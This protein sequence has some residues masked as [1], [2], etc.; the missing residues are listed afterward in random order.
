MVDAVYRAPGG[1]ELT[2]QVTFQEDAQVP[3]DW[4][5][6]IP[7]GE[8]GQLLYR[9]S[10][11][12]SSGA[13]IES[14][15]TPVDERTIYVN[16]LFEASLDLTFFV[17]VDLEQF[18]AVFID[19]SY[20]DRSNNYERQERAELVPGQRRA[21]FHIGLIDGSKRQYEYELTF[22]AEGPLHQPTQARDRRDR[23]HGRG[24]NERASRVPAALELLAP[25]APAETARASLALDRMLEGV[26]RSRWGSVAWEA[27]GLTWDGFPLE[28]SFAS[29]D[30]R[31]RYVAEVAAPS[32]RCRRGLADA[33]GSCPRNMSTPTTT[34]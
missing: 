31:I 13:T 23:G 10:S 28:F 8:K 1:G 33:L 22:V 3:H 21:N 19:V 18:E 34:S 27:S 32:D 6:R 24:M 7:R 11:H 16:D 12:L 4:K 14:E 5:L 2:K 17:G 25:G 20:V 15:L 26:R 29:G 9:L 30:S